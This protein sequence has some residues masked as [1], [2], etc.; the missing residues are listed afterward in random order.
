M[1]DTNSSKAGEYI[2]SYRSKMK[3]KFQKNKEAKNALISTL[4]KEDRTPQKIKE[5]NEEYKA[6]MK[7]FV[8][9]LKA[10][11]NFE[12]YQQKYREDMIEIRKV[13]GIYADYKHKWQPDD[14]KELLIQSF[15]KA[16]KAAHG[17]PYEWDKFLKN[18]YNDMQR[19]N[20]SQ[21][22]KIFSSVATMLS[23][24]EN[25]ANAI[26]G[27]KNMDTFDK[28]TYITVALL[29]IW[30]TGLGISMLDNEANHLI[31]KLLWASRFVYWVKNIGKTA[32]VASIEGGRN[33]VRDTLKPH[34]FNYRV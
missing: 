24:P 20:T 7:A 9:K 3:H 22:E 25:I 2:D 17:L 26:N 32:K 27:I 19:L 33:E 5:I 1:I 18:I 11:E 23:S 8:E 16:K 12:M 6:D 14:A 34:K 31:V 4:N 13:L 21:K 30:M 15:S 10:D 29:V 28:F